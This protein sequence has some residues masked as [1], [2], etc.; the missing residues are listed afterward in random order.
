M[1]IFLSLNG[2]LYRFRMNYNFW[3]IYLCMWNSKQ[4]V[5]KNSLR[6]GPTLLLVNSRKNSNAQKLIIEIHL[7]LGAHTRWQAYL[8]VGTEMMMLNLRWNEFHFLLGMLKDSWDIFTHFFFLL[9]T[10]NVLACGVFFFTVCMRLFILK[11]HVWNTRKRK[12][13]FIIIILIMHE[14]G[15]GNSFFFLSIILSSV[16]RIFLLESPTESIFGHKKRRTGHIAS[17]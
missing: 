12:H 1:L 13:Y 10:S 5:S 11:R 14:E 16:E 4:K 9:L 8:L 3:M 2:P 6:L 17:V 7:A 15:N